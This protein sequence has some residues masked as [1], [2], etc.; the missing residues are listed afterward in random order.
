[1]VTILI[2]LTSFLLFPG[3]ANAMVFTDPVASFQRKL[4]L[5]YDSLEASRTVI[6]LQDTWNNLQTAKMTYD[7]ARAGYEK[8][9]NPKEWEALAEYS[10]YRLKS[11]AN[12]TPDPYQ[13]VLYKTVV[14]MD[15]AADAYIM[16][17]KAYGAM[18]NATG[19]FGESIGRADQ[20]FGDGVT[21]MPPTFMLSRTPLIGR[22]WNGGQKLGYEILITGLG[23]ISLFHF[24]NPNNLEGG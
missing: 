11:L 5:M 17:T 24:N 9:T 21:T 6:L 1:M 8:V 14:S 22:R 19:G 13:T 12:P 20:R 7:L 10:K 3:K 18:A 4:Q 16:N 23:G 2:L 15:R